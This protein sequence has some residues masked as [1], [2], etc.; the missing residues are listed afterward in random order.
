MWLS[1]LNSEEIESI[2]N[3]IVKYFNEVLRDKLL[4]FDDYVMDFIFL[5]KT[6]YA[7]ELNQ[8]GQE[9]GAGSSLFEWKTDH[10]MLYGNVSEIGFR[11]VNR[12]I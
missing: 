3:S 7:I 2:A 10:E 6:P 8:F 12:E 1:T 11:Y 9:Y 4:S 5:D